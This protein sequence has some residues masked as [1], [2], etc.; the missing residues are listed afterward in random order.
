MVI[1]VGS[2]TLPTLLKAVAI[3]KNTYT[4]LIVHSPKR[5]QYSNTR[6]V[7][8]GSQLFDL[9]TISLSTTPFGFEPMTL[10]LIPLVGP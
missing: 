8:G 2:Q 9:P 6:G 4:N 5:P 3:R 1:T 7:D 10:A